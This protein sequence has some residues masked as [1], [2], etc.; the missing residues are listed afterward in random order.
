MTQQ[1]Q[2]VI[3]TAWEQRTELSPQHASAEVRDAVAH[4]LDMLNQGQLRVATRDGVGRWTTHQWIKKA[5]L[6]SFRLSDNA[7][8][9][10]GE[11]GFFDKVPT[12]FSR[13]SEDELRSSGV[14]IV[15]PAVARYGS[16][17]AR[18]VILMPS[19]V[20]IGAYVGDGTMVDVFNVVVVRS[21]PYAE[22]ARAWRHREA[23]R[24]LLRWWRAAAARRRV[25]G[26]PLAGLE[27]AAR[28]RP[29]RRWPGGALGDRPEAA[30]HRQPGGGACQRPPSV[31]SPGH[32]GRLESFR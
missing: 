25:V 9:R 22:R 11:L 7:L 19:Y 32:V 15:P 12:R 21:R 31:H 24:R 2:T 18:G 13:L 27:R 20:N 16:F 5:V 3:E 10:A 23:G 29:A 30:A 6:L 8:M 26:G 14:R 17:Q 28:L 1:L 4:A